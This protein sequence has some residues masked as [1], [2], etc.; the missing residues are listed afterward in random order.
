MIRWEYMTRD[1]VSL[2]ELNDLGAAG[3]ELVGLQDVMVPDGDDS[4]SARAQLVFKW[5]A[6]D[7]RD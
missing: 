2:E 3:W 1:C 6:D 7:G 5:R 4:E